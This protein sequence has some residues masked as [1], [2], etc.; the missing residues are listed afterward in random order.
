MK[1]IMT[2]LRAILISAVL[3]S[4]NIA[5]AEDSIDNSNGRPLRFVWGA[6]IDG[7]VEMSGHDMSTLGID[8]TFGMQ[9]KWIRFFGVNAEADI[10]VSNSARTFPLTLNFRTDFSSRQ[11]L[12]FA[13]L[14]GGIALNYYDGNTQETQPYASGGIGITLATGRTFSSHLIVGYTYLGRNECYVGNRGR[15][16]PGMSYASIRLGVQF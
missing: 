16:C 6:G 5:Q 2:V 8:A 3:L 12:L 11:R 1:K 14:R 10:M 4:P 9:Y 15:K 13:D 7:G